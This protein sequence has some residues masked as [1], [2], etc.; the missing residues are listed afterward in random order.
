[1]FFKKHNEDE[2]K[3]IKKNKRRILIKNEKIEFKFLWFYLN[4][5]FQVFFPFM[6]AGEI[7]IESF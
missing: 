4:F 3:K 2:Q 6:F 1:M 7:S 5:Y